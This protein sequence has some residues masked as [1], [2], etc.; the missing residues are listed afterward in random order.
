MLFIVAIGVAGTLLILFA[1]R[2]SD[3]HRSRLLQKLVATPIGMLGVFLLGIAAIVIGASVILPF[4]VAI[5][6][7]LF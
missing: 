3:R 4:F 7:M 6:T 5:L 2:F 1:N